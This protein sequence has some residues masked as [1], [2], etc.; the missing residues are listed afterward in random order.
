[1]NRENIEKGINLLER[2]E[3]HYLPVAVALGVKNKR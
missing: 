3:A 2:T 1:M